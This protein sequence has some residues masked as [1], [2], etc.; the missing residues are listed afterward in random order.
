MNAPASGSMPPLFA[1]L[2]RLAQLQ[3][4]A[5]DRLALREAAEAA[6]AQDAGPRARLATVARHLQVSGAR[7]LKT[8]DPAITPVLLFRPDG[9]CGIL[10]GK[11][12]QD[13]WVSEWWDPLENRWRE[14]ADDVL[15]GHQAA[16]LRVARPY[17]A[18]ASPLFQLIRHEI[19]SHRATIR[20]VVLCGLMINVVTMIA[21]FYSMQVYDR[22]IP[23]GGTQTLLVLTL[24]VLAVAGFE[25]VARRLRSGLYEKLV[26]Q[27][28]QRLARTVYLRFLGVRL[29]QLPHSVGS[30]ASQMRG[31][32]TVRSFFT[33]TTTNLLVDAPFAL[34]FMLVIFAVG[35]PIALVPLVFFLLSIGIG[36]YYHKQVDAHARQAT[37]ASNRKA[38][39]LVET[40]EGAETIK[41]GQGGWRMLARWMR[42]TDS[43]RDSELEMRSISEHS[44]HLTALFQQCSYVLLVAFGALQVGQGALTMGGLIACSIL[45][46]RVLG[47]VSMIPAQLMQW[48]HTRAALQGLDRLWQLEADH[49]GE[50]P[51]VV[52][53][54][55]GHYRFD[56]VAFQYQG[57]PA[58]S[59]P[60]LEIRPGE[61]VGILG[62]VGAGKT[63]LLRLLSG[64]YKP[65]QGRILLDDVD[66]AQ[67]AKPAL[68]EHVGYVQQD[69]RLFAGTLRENLILGLLDPGDDVILAV[70]RQTGL[71]G[72]VI[73]R[74]PKGLQQ[75]IFEGG[76]GLSGGQRQLVNLT[77]AFLRQPRIWL[78]D[79][80]TASMDRALEAQVTD[81]LR[82]TLDSSTTLV[83][84]THKA[85]MLDLVDRLIVV[86]DR[87][88][89]LDGPKAQVLRALQPTPI[90]QEAA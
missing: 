60:S 12:G 27:V 68:A 22:V 25:L 2:I 71:L 23:T 11:N 26:D 80:P 36:A 87:K 86:A 34:V 3:H 56:G 43:A 19:F 75:E 72:S 39:L 6:L 47:P 40:V 38:G 64:M 18:H 28:D 8:P 90:R 41:S 24:G 16:S 31:Y 89:V 15:A 13:Q 1:C 52:E 7:W 81:A 10:R 85:D 50:E 51:V 45:A 33:S 76:S 78:L 48:A 58:I 37:A 57:N 9:E 74:H 88:I 65:H 55:R 67:I 84:V 49:Q 66:L 70:S 14:Q 61:K 83:L 29:D 63:T 69:G 44:Q 73:A 46:G 82:A 17:A 54:L 59:V 42:T 4:E 62:P 5:V 35:G 32:E 20:E 79:E 21:S 53:H 30:L 77:R